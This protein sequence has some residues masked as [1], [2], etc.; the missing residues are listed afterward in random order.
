MS[1]ETKQPSLNRQEAIADMRFCVDHM[2]NDVAEMSKE[3]KQM[4]DN[5]PRQPVNTQDNRRR[6]LIGV[7]GAAIGLW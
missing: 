6:G 3:L 2:L 4:R 1:H 7:I 5:S